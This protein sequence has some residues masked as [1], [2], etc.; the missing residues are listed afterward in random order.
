MC[1]PPYQVRLLRGMGGVGATLPH[2][3]RQLLLQLSSVHGTIFEN[4]EQQKAYASFLV[5]GAADVLA[6]PLTTAGE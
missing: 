6:A 5:K 2:S 3:L 4:D 1:A